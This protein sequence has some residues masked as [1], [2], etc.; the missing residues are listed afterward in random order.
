MRAQARAAEGSEKQETSVYAGSPIPLA[1]SHPQ[2]TCAADRVLEH[3]ERDGIADDEFVEGR[4]VAHIRAVK[5]NLAT[6]GHT[7]VPVSLSDE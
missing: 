3:F 5:K 7:D 6:P 4:A 1:R 2:R